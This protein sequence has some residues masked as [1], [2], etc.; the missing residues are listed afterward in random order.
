MITPSFG[1]TATERVLPKLALDFT[2]AN[3]DSRITFARALDTATRINSS[4]QLEVVLADTPRFDYDPTTLVCKGLLIEESRV[5]SLRNNTMQGVVAGTPGTTPTNWVVSSTASGITREV[6]GTGTD[7]GVDYIDLRYYGTASSAVTVQ[8]NFES[9]TQIAASNGQTWTASTYLKLVAG[10]IANTTSRLLILAGRDALGNTVAGQQATSVGITPTTA[11]ILSQRSTLSF[12]FSSVLVA[13]A[14]SSFQFNVASGATIDLTLRVGLPQLELGAFATSVIKTSTAAVTRNAD[15]ASMTGTNFSD[16]FN[17]SEGTLFAEFT[18]GGDTI[19]T[20]VAIIDDGT[21][22][23]YIG[24][25][26]STGSSAGPFFAVNNT[27]AQCAIPSPTA[28]AV[29][30]TYKIAG[31][32]KADNFA[33][34]INGGTLATDVSGTIPTVSQMQIGRDAFPNYLNGL[35]RR[36]MY[37][38]QRLTNAEVRAFSKG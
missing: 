35:V 2:T 13:F 6:V 19:A 8:I 5:N 22:T 33:A 30:T 14:R 25:L 23:N 10:S 9:N 24:I 7:N 31:A 3:L 15:V 16:W 11:N 29:N 26:G 34:A 21:T 32:Y 17:A 20:R 38:P 18:T 36:I 28:I 1:L 27:T 4:G 37:W 12:T